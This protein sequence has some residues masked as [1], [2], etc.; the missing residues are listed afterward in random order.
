[1]SAIIAALRRDLAMPAS[2]RI[3]SWE[4]VQ[5]VVQSRGL[6]GGEYQVHFMYPKP[7]SSIRVLYMLTGVQD[8]SFRSRVGGR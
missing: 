7:A 4:V 2:H 8:F 5:S 6:L 3:N 1:M